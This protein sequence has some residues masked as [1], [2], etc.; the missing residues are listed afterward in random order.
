MYSAIPKE[1]LEVTVA[2][3][4]QAGVK[5]QNEDSIGIRMPSGYLQSTKGIAAIIADGVSAA[6]GGKEASEICV[7]GFLNDYFSTPDSWSVKKS[8]G[9]VFNALNRWL[10][11]RGMQYTQNTKGYV[12]TMSAIVLKSRSAYIF[13]VG[14]TRIYR[15]RNDSIEQLTKDH[16]VP[17]GDG[18]TYLT[19]AMGLDT[20]LDIDYQCIDIE[21]GDL[22]FLSSDGI[23]DV[24]SLVELTAIINNQQ[25]SLEQRC[26]QL[27][28]LAADKC[29][30]DNLSCQLIHVDT[31][32]AFNKD[33]FCRQLTQLPFP[34]LLSPGQSLD[35]LVIEKELHASNRSQVYLIRDTDN[36]HF[37]MKTP[38]DNYRDD[39]AYI[40]DRKSVV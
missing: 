26:Q 21:Q 40:E 17:V 36:R 11:S 20:R 3:L 7:K 18:Q 8:G 15:V 13:H 9:V 19:R 29:S 16:A 32:P 2:Q 30:N 22:F 1:S 31:L 25:F 28:E 4:S 35:N 39:A 34:P 38:S 27:H 14:D 37:I 23:H 33:E 5:T 10:Y 6:E 12:S 24:I